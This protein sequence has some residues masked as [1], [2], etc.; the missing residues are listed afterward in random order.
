MLADNGARELQTSNGSMTRTG[1]YAADGAAALDE[2][3]GPRTSIATWAGFEFNICK[4]ETWRASFNLEDIARALANI[5]RFNGH[6]DF[7]SVAEHAVRVSKILEE[8][9]YDKMTQLIGLHHDDTEAYLGD[10]PSPQKKLMTIWGMPFKDFEEY[11]ANSHLFP[12]LGLEVT[13]ERW[14]AVK[15][16]DYQSYLEERSRRPRPRGAGAAKAMTPI[17]AQIS[18]EI[19]HQRLMNDMEAGI[20]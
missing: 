15:K 12:W 17:T 2:A 14:A 19:L 11:M 10:I 5:C 6:V 8:N 13:E 20:E 1:P 16:A 9:G 7:Y 18:Y 3:P 4:P